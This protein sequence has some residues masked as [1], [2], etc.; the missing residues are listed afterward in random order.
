M[1]ILDKVEKFGEM[2][3]KNIWFRVFMLL[4]FIV[5]HLYI[6]LWIHEF[7]HYWYGSAIDNA[8]CYVVYD[9]KGIRGYTIC[10]YVSLGNFAI[11]SLGTALVFSIYWFFASSFPSKLTLPYDL[12]MFLVVA[13]NL[14]YFPFEF[15]GLGLNQYWLY[16][17]YWVG[18][19]VAMFITLYLYFDRIVWFIAKGDAQ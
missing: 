16:D 1:T 10:N 13:I 3:Y 5:F 19:I 6:A 12:S 4:F 8:S 18:E 9:L 14:F 2:L 15:I 7:F 11:G 17:Y